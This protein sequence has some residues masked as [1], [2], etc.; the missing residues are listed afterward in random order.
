MG[1]WTTR[2]S[3]ERDQRTH[4]K[5]PFVNIRFSNVLPQSRGRVPSDPVTAGQGAERSFHHSDDSTWMDLVIVF[6]FVL[7]Y[8]ISFIYLSISLS[9]YLF[10]F[11]VR[12]LNGFESCKSSLSGISQLTWS[13]QTE[14]WPKLRGNFDVL[15]HCWHTIALR[16]T[17][18]RV[19]FLPAPR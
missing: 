18:F 1:P 16:L 9:I 6:H 17:Y 15:R 10:Y 11:G 4:W 5:Q 14:Q 8:F 3:R 19:P 2:S 13:I 12:R 7:F